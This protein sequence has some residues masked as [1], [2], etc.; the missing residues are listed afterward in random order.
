MNHSELKPL[1]FSKTCTGFYSALNFTDSSRGRTFAVKLL[2]MWMFILS[3]SE[4]IC[5]QRC[6]VRIY[7]AT[8]IEKYFLYSSTKKKKRK[9][10]NV[11]AES[12][13]FVLVYLRE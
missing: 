3:I 10:L 9:K 4:P 7:L 11:D 1:I 2:W 8:C 13:M 6:L 5:L 12:E